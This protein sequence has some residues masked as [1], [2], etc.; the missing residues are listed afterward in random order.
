[1]ALENS[2]T[3]EAPSV[4]PTQGTRVYRGSKA[5]ARA[6]RVLARISG[7]ATEPNSFRGLYQPVSF[8][9]C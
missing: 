3:S 6:A 9:V 5:R 8:K 2:G 4:P 1:M 7:T